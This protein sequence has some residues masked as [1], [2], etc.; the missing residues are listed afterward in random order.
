MFVFIG[1]F[2]VSA[3]PCLQMILTHACRKPLPRLEYANCYGFVFTLRFVV[4]VV[5]MSV[6]SLFA[7]TCMYVIHAC[8]NVNTKNT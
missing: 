4:V 8:T 3:C 5:N 2:L 6:A 1:A 7:N